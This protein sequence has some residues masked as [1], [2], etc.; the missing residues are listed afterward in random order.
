MGAETSL[1]QALPQ[2]QITLSA[3]NRQRKGLNHQGNDP[4]PQIIKQTDSRIHTKE[5]SFLGGFGP[6]E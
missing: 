6:Q 1:L 4:G 5:V 3:H 2:S